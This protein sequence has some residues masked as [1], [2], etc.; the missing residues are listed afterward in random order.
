MSNDKKVAWTELQEAFTTFITALHTF[1]DVCKKAQEEDKKNRFD[2]VENH[3]LGNDSFRV[4]GKRASLC[5]IDE[6]VCASDSIKE[7]LL[8]FQKV[9]SRTSG[10]TNPHIFD[11]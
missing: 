6:D 9:C 8:E 11:K 5:C 10:F 2:S 1:E 7:S 4:Q 3:I